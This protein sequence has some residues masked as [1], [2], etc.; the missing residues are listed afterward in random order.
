[1]QQKAARISA[2][3]SCRPLEQPSGRAVVV[4]F[5]SGKKVGTGSTPELDH[6]N[7]QK[8]VTS[9]ASANLV[10][11]DQERLFTHH[12]RCELFIITI[13]LTGRSSWHGSLPWPVDLVEQLLS[14][15]GYF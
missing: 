14:G 12:S 11:A 8:R 15:N 10:G 3:S 4:A 7:A 2:T 13:S 9:H 6:L 1:L 5:F